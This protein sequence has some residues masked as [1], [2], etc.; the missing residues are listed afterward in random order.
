MR[1]VYLI[2]I[3]GKVSQEGYD[4]LEKAQA[5]M[6]AKAKQMNTY[7]KLEPQIEPTRATYFVDTGLRGFNDP[8]KERTIRILFI[9]IKEG[10][11]K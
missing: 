8:F 3:D 10:E 4:N 11:K 9:N 5:Y 1:E 7:E 2:E 6:K